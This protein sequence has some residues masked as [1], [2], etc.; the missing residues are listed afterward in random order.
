MPFGNRKKN[1]LKDIF[2]SDFSQFKKY[3]SGTLK[4]NIFKHFP[5]LQIAQFNGE[6]PPNFS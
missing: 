3:P 1:I 6:K 4:F 5:K 2:V